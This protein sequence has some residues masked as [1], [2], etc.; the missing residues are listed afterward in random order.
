MGPSCYKTT[1]RTC[2]RSDTILNAL[3]WFEKT[4]NKL[5]RSGGEE[6]EEMPRF[7]DE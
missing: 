3:L 4:Q 5:I 2:Y 6:E 1:S 7:I